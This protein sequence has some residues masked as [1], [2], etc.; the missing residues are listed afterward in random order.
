[1]GGYV[2]SMFCS[3]THPSHQ[4]MAASEDFSRVLAITVY[5]G[6]YLSTNYGGKWV[7]G[8]MGGWVGG[9]VGG[10]DSMGGVGG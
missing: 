6:I 8:W 9:W 7:G 1:M 5:K 4:S 10:W 3:P 2:Y